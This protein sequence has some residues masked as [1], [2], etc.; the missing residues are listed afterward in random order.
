MFFWLKKYNKESYDTSTS[1][2]TWVL[3]L[4]TA[5]CTCSVSRCSWEITWAWCPSIAKLV[6]AN[7]TQCP[8]PIH[9]GW[10]TNCWWVATSETTVQEVHSSEESEKTGE[11]VSLCSEDDTGTCC[12]WHHV[13]IPKT[14]QIPITRKNCCWWAIT[15]KKT[16]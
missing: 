7:L 16:K 2:I 4:R 8:Q 13:R 5:C 1:S 14:K 12:C 3:Q 15:S 6:G 10:I 11:V 9:P